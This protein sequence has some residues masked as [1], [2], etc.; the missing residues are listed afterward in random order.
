MMID[1][2]GHVGIQ[3]LNPNCAFTIA[4]G[5]GQAIND[6][7]TA[8]SSRRWKTNIQPLHNALSMVEQLR[9]VSYDLKASG[10]HEIGVIAEE[11]GKI[12]PAVVNYEENGKDAR[13]VDYSLANGTVD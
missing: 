7:C 2:S 6:G 3:T 11:V 1:S 4:Q 13:G 10:K 9:S 8:Y 5:E 12:V